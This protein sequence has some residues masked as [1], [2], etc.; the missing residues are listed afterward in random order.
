MPRPPN[1]SARP[2]RPA[3]PAAS[4]LPFYAAAAPGLEPL[5]LRELQS[6]GVAG[7]RL[8]AGGVAFG[9]GNIALYRANLW[10]RVASRVV[11][12]VSSFHADSFRELERHARLVPW[13]E[14]LAPGQSVRFRVTCR[15]SRLY[16][17]DAVAERM[18]AA[19][20]HRLR[21]A[22]P[23]LADGD[24]GEDDSDE[25]ESAADDAQ[26]F[27]VRIAHDHCVVSADSSGSLLHR[28]GYRQALA[29]APLRETLAAAALAGSGWAPGAALMDPMCGS[30]TIAIEAA[31]MA[32][33]IAPG[34]GRSFAFMRWP[35]FDEPRWTRML[36]DA[37]AQVQASAG[38]PI[39]ASDRD[40][41]AMEAA[42]ANAARAGVADDIT[43]LERP[44]SAIEPPAELGWVVT[45]PPYGVR[46]GERDGLRNLYAG[47]G[48][49]LRERFPAWTLAV[50][51]A[52]RVLEGQI[53]VPFTE[54]FQSTNGGIPVR[55]AVGAAGEVAPV[56]RGARRPRRGGRNA[57][58][59]AGVESRS[60]G[61]E[62][63]EGFNYL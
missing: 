3:T 11:V 42:K 46:V 12:R 7:A 61:D 36:D 26:L 17:S 14:F 9:G 59:G 23:R 5:V 30:G 54:A 25:G 62:S 19:V 33:R 21:S 2:G 48:R 24:A 57:E 16:H 13:E 60:D 53:G 29:K 32:R 56:A 37:A 58:P 38:A 40:A 34:L 31:M 28:R 47:F 15:K 22:V 63:V 4:S 49:V 10:L 52:D 41:G 51:S 39:V 43:F 35:S 1:P 27:T 50:L 8:E 55:L 44:I 45:N 20:A 6:L 18:A